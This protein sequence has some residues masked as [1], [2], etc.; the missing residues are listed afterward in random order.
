MLAA[1]RQLLQPEGRLLIS[2]PNAGYTGL[3]AELLEGEFLYRE[4]GLLDRHAADIAQPHL[5]R[6][7]E[8][9]N[10]ASRVTPGAGGREQGQQEEKAMRHH[11][12]STGLGGVP[13]AAMASP[14]ARRRS[15]R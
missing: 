9:G 15:S 5:A 8:R 3:I 13:A 4:E 11:V 6:A 1:C 12:G 14:A 2:V 7:A 10:G